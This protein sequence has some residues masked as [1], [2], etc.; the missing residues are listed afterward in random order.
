MQFQ[1]FGGPPPTGVVFDCDLASIDDALA[2][3]LLFGFDGKNEARVASLSISR[4]SLNAV[5]YADAVQR[6][7][8]GGSG[9]FIRTLP[10]G[11]ALEGAK[12][13]SEPLVDAPLAKPE[14]K[15]AIT[16]LNDT[17]DAA[18]AIRNAFTAFHDGNCMAVLA[19]PS[20]NIRQALALRGAREII[21]AKCRHLTVLPDAS[22]AGN[23]TKLIADWP[24]DV[25]VIDPEVGKQVM[26]PASVVETAFTWSPAHPVVE[27][28]KRTRRCVR[29]AHR[30]ACRRSPC[31]EAQ[32]KL[33]QVSEPGVVTIDANGK[34]QHSPSAQGKHRV[35]S[36]DPA[37]AERILKVYTELV[38]RSPVVAQRFRPG[39]A[40]PKPDAPKPDAAKP[41]EAKPPAQ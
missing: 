21:S 12:P 11:M 28:Y 39:A 41:A 22:D 13:G 34:L 25:Y 5:A 14:F 29:R 37:Q 24:S 38:A 36:H 19:G 26:F 2:L 15:P 20:I 31:S 6:F 17:A 32:G 30:I 33:L 1:G 27:A 16:K 18:A 35:V 23:T 9:P 10:I 3:S 7:Y 40:K 4:P 8:A